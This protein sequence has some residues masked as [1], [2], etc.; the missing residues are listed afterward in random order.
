MNDNGLKI[1]IRREL[2]ELEGET[3][4]LLAQHSLRPSLDAG[5]QQYPMNLHC[6][7]LS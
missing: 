2:G 1:L 6:V 3:W 7:V 5:Y 4:I